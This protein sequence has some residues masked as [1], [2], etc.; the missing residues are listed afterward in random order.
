MIKSSHHLKN[1]ILKLYKPIA[2]MSN[3]ISDEYIKDNGACSISGVIYNKENNSFQGSYAF[4]EMQV[5]KNKKFSRLF[6]VEY[7]G[8]NTV[9]AT[10]NG[11]ITNILEN[12]DYIIENH[13]TPSD[14][15]YN[16]D[17]LYISSSSNVYHLDLNEE[18][19]KIAFSFTPYMW[20]R[21][22]ARQSDN[23]LANSVMHYGN[24]L[25]FSD[26][27]GAGY[28]SIDGS[29]VKILNSELKL[30]DF[31]ICGNSLFA[32]DLYDIYVISGNEIMH[33]LNISYL[34]ITSRIC[35][36][37]GY[38]LLLLDYKNTYEL[39]EI[40]TLTKVIKKYDIEVLKGLGT[41][42][43]KYIRVIDNKLY[44]LINET[45]ENITINRASL[46]RLSFTGNEYIISETLF[47]NY[48]I[49]NFLQDIFYINSKLMCY[50]AS[51]NIYSSLNENI[52]LYEYNNG[53]LIFLDY[54][55]SPANICATQKISVNGNRIYA[56]NTYGIYFMDIMPSDE[57]IPCLL[58]QNGRLIVPQGS[59]LYFSG[60]G[61]F[62]NWSWNTDSDA[63]FTEI[64]YKEG[65]NIIYAA[66]VLDSII[67]FKDNGSIYRLA[68]NYP[69]WTVSKLGEIDKLTTKV[70][71]LGSEIIFGA[72]SGIKKIGV[73]EYYGDFFLSDFQH[74]IHDKNILDISLNLERNTIIFINNDYIFEYNIIL[75]AWTIYQFNKSDKLK[76]IIEVYDNINNLY[77]SYGL[78]VN[79]MLY[80]ANKNILNDI[81]IIYKKI[82][83][84][85]NILIKSI[86]F[87]TPILKSD[88]IFTLNINDISK[89]L[90]LKAGQTRHKYFITKKLD[91]LQIKLSHK[92]DFFIDNIFIEYSII[93]K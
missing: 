17:G 90:S 51:I 40:N 41:Y 13:I 53:Q 82:K 81:N 69:Y 15:I 92:G 1:N 33:F 47:E 85:Q 79:G 19:N 22:S 42:G 72:T 6:N 76:Q 59:H 39:Y 11:G 93:G 25:Y 14:I 26:N 27:R 89:N 83:S 31:F 48:L 5:Y 50:F 86:L 7:K 36:A 35:A 74:S 61:D 45:D 70:I 9:F 18:I 28:M 75:K 55:N 46:Y 52:E 3:T 78:N 49:N 65:G 34:G 60:A 8:K 62:Y 24:K 64:G 38:N 4:E 73:T 32:A 66:L 88:K 12:K 77:L 44:L 68:G 63:L 2:G 91:E 67:V 21:I 56:A 58:V 10:Y 54:S 30:L 29:V 43:L 87:F 20:Q 71:T 80:K 16:Q 37:V 57:N 23:A 84:N